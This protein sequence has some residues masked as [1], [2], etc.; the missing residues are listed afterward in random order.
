MDTFLYIAGTVLALTGSV[1]AVGAKHIFHAALGLAIALVGTAGLFVPLNGEVVSVVQLLVYL[2][3]VAI[4]IVFT[5]MLSPPYYLQRPKRSPRKALA[6][7][8]IALAFVAPLAWI[9]LRQPFVI[10]APRTTDV[11]IQ[12]IGQAMLSTFVFPF[13]IISLVLTIV[14]IGA[15]VIA[16]DLPPLKADAESQRQ[17]T[18]MQPSRK[19]EEMTEVHS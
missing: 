12:E 19:T 5:L 3:A 8:L 14:I 11:S 16:R 17:E 1:I 7:A 6:A 15:I 13:E 9:A 18:V 4:A 2:G 10:A